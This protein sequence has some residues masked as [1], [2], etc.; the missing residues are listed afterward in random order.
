VARRLF[1]AHLALLVLA[2]AVFGL[3][4]AG[5][6]RTR[7]LEEIARRLDAEAEVVAAI[8]RTGPAPASLHALL[9]EMGR[10]TDVRLTVIA[11]DGTVIAES[12]ADPARMENHN[13]RPEVQEARAQGRGRNVRTSETVRTDMMY[14]ALLSD[15]AR[16]EGIVIRAALPLTRVEEEI[17]ALYRGIV[18]AFVVVG[19]AGG[20]VT[21]L[22]ARWITGPLRGI[23]TVAQAIA[24]GD[25]TRRAPLT[26][27]DE[28]GSVSAAINRMAEE[29]ERR[30]VRLTAEGAKLDAALSSL[31]DGVVAL[32]GDGKILHHNAAAASLLS[33]GPGSA[34]IR[35]WETVRVPG[36]EER[37]REALQRGVLVRHAV[38]AGARTLELS[39]SPLRGSAGCVLVARDV[40]EERRYDRLRKEFVANVS[41]ELRTPLSVIRGYVET[42]RDGAL[43]D[44]ENAP[45]FLES[46]EK[47]VE[48]LSLLVDDLLELSRLESAGPALK[49]RRM[50]GRELLGKVLEDFRPLAEKKR[51]TLVLDAPVPFSCEADPD[52]LERALRNLVDNAIKYT[53]EGGT[54]TLCGAMDG[55]GAAFAVEDTG[56]GVPATDLPRIFE[57]FYRVDKSRSRELGGT[58]LGLAIVKHVAQLHGGTIGV[59]SKVG[60]GSRFTLRIPGKR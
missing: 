15:P 3:L 35:I 16:R 60:S 53:P 27:T 43:K 52:L 38:E 34:G 21:V 18:I 23:R 10:R 49:V 39:F 17:G 51:Q 13:A 1:L 26:A 30:L 25:F 33:L 20:G 54:V 2:L 28:I 37:A 40:T 4:A 48:R 11:G 44:E 46:I 19:L 14:F 50:D 41:H 6:T 59:E 12:H 58:G 9:Q 8:V 42:L 29:L 36:L 5:S 31:Q 22:V 55:D 45:R 7:V 57:R 32:D 24:E 56:I 47:N